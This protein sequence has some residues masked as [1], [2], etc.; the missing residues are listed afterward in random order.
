MTP[1]LPGTRKARRAALGAELRRLRQLASV[2]QHEIAGAL[3]VNPATVSRVEAGERPLSLPD[4]RAWAKLIGADGD[5]LERLEWM[6][7]Q[8]LTESVP[9]DDVRAAGAPAIQGDIYQRLELPSRY[10]A[11]WCPSYLTGLLQTREYAR[12]VYALIKPPAEVDAA[13]AARLGRQ[14]VLY[15]AGHRLEFILAEA[16]LRWRSGQPDFLRPQLDR[17]IDLA[18][19]PNVEM[20]VIPSDADMLVPPLGE[21][22]LYDER[23]DGPVVGIEALHDDIETGDAQPYREELVRLRRSGLSGDEA[24]AFIRDLAARLSA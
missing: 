19:Y 9:M 10:I 15:E 23:D 3:N 7:E 4:L 12:R 8:A 22:V 6:A 14:Q 20:R 21:F 1:R 13:V 18:G 2:S 16:A 5:V 24:I 11:A 17:L